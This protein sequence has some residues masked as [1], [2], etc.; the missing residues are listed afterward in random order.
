M[1]LKYKIII[2]LLVATLVLAVLFLPAK[3]NF[4]GKDETSTEAQKTEL[5][6]SGD[7]FHYFMQARAASKPVVLEFHARW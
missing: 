7:P 4:T 1:S 5:V 3:D 6:D 2:V